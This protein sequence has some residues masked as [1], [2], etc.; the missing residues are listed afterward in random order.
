MPCLE[1]G[2]K[3]TMIYY[4]VEVFSQAKWPTPA[5][6]ACFNGCHK[7]PW[8]IFVI[9]LPDGRLT[10]Q[11]FVAFPRQSIP[12]TKFQIYRTVLLHVT[13]SCGLPEQSMPLQPEAQEQTQSCSFNVPPF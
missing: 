10:P 11:H 9:L 12:N 1:K 6:L 3:E 8:G 7:A 2:L 5:E 13:D 4:S